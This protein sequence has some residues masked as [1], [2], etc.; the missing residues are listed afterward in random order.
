MIWSTRTA[1]DFLTPA[2][3]TAS[4]VWPAWANFAAE[5]YQRG[6][7][8]AQKWEIH[9]SANDVWG[10]YRKDAKGSSDLSSYEKIGYHSGTGELLR[11]FL[12]SGRPIFV[13]RVMDPD[14]RCFKLENGEVIE[15]PREVKV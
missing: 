2:K 5:Q 12:D 1:A 14:I 8:L 15:V 4:E 11:G 9:I 13:H 7:E 10:G 6:L 3:F